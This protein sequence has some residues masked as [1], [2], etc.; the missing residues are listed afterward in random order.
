M[1]LSGRSLL[2][3]DLPQAYGKAVNMTVYSFGYGVNREERRAS[4]ETVSDGNFLYRPGEKSRVR[5]SVLV[6][7]KVEIF[8]QPITWQPDWKG[9]VSPVS[10]RTSVDRRAKGTPLAG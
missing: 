8:G 9:Q 7:L 3:S 6:S 5:P 1:L 4:D 10:S 2:G